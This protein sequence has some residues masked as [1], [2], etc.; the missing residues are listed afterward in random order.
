MTTQTDDRRLARTSLTGTLPVLRSETASSS[1]PLARS[2]VS[3]GGELLRIG[4]AATHPPIPATECYTVDMGWPVIAKGANVLLRCGERADVLLM[5]SG[6]G[7]EVNHSLKLLSLNAAVLE[8]VG[9]SRQWAFFCKSQ[10]A[11]LTNLGILALRGVTHHG[12][13]SYFTLPPSPSCSDEALRWVCP[14]VPEATVLPQIATV[15]TCAQT[16]LQR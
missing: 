16:A 13:G 6:L 11:S 3:T 12:D 4:A 7:G 14:P 8:I 10:P 15:V 5:P 1:I 2:A 9:A